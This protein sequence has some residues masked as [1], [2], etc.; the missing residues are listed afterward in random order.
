MAKPFSWLASY[1]KSGNTWV[2]IFLGCYINDGPVDINSLPYDMTHYDLK[3][4]YYR[5]IAPRSLGELSQYEVFNLRPAV[6]Q[7]MYHMGQWPL[8]IKTHNARARIHNTCLIP[9]AWTERA[10]YLVRDPRDVAV[11][12]ANHA[13]RSLDDTIE[14]MDDPTAG[15]CHTTEP[16]L[17]HFLGTWST[18]VNSWMTTDQFPARC[19]RYED[20]KEKPEDQ[21]SNLL[22]FLEWE[23]IPDRVERAVEFSKFSNLRSQEQKTGFKELTNGSTFFKK[24]EVGTWKE[25]LTEDQVKRIEKAH[26]EVMRALGYET[27]Y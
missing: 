7:H 27:T 1:P 8:L 9:A 3:T 2:R 20:F 25:T 11:S 6:L 19:F 13:R 4:H 15:S 16:S 23:V 22:E 26:G 14:M 21:F 12:F 10:V 18:H 17:A 5:A 24:G